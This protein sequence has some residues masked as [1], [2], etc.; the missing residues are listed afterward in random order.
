MEALKKNN[1]NPVI[2]IIGGHGRM[3]ALFAEFFKL[4]GIKVLISDVGTNLTN[5]ELAQKSDIII[6]SV[7]IDNTE[8][9]I[10]EVLP[11]MRYGSA[12]MDF[13]S[14]KQMPVLAMLK[15]NC[16]VM[17]MHPM[18]GNS[19]PIPGQTVIL[20]RTKKSEKWSRW[21]A[22]FLRRNNVKIE[23][24]SAVEHD[25][26]MNIAQ[27]L[28][29][30]AEITFADGLRRAGLPMEK[31]FKFTGKASELKIQLAARIIDQDPGL[32]GN[33]QIA[34]PYALNS[35]KKYK[36]SVDELLKIVEKKDLKGFKKYFLKNREFFGNY[37]KQ[38]YRDSSYLLDKFIELKKIEKNPSQIKP[39]LSHI[40][41]L[42]PKNTFSD[43]AAD[44]Y[45][46]SSAAKSS[47]VI[48]K[49]YFV[50][51]L[52]EIF[53][54]VEKGKVKEGIAPIENKLHGTIRETLDALFVRNVHITKEI[55]IPIHHCLIVLP[56][57]EKSDIKKIISHSQ[58]LHQCKKYL[59]KNFPKAL[60]GSFSS[61]GAAI[62]KLLSSNDKSVAVI[63]PELAAEGL[64]ILAKNIEDEH[65]NST[66]FV[67]IKRGAVDYKKSTSEQKNS[68]T[69]PVGSY[70]KT[71]IAFHFSA[72]SPGSLFTVFKDFADAKINLTKIESRPTKKHFGD[73][74][75]YLDF[76]GNINDPKV[77]KVLSEVEKKVAKLKVLGSY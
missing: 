14:I 10:R 41:V 39:T 53:D 32:Y 36:Q 18:F 21:M 6:V 9:V 25:K 59:Q 58:A 34:N 62:E 46:Q 71:S 50:R 70:G 13:T 47:T 65:D 56:H 67:V 30:F 51:E 44:Q 1:P 72:D 64:K 35:L 77:R 63:A 27:G 57:A 54:L 15:G 28:I 37:T 17:G 16:E 74:I 43:I 31:L 11:H 48:L 61:T 76:A 12:I 23:E 60:K 75:F 22:D 45:L 40:A 19:N 20:C 49:K 42:G 4:R 38:A 2:G 5:H 26:I 29:H 68:S 33:I 52:D 73:Y 66:A 3:G 8:K 7:P 55:N 24:M 69:S